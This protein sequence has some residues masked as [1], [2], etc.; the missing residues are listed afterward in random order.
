MIGGAQL[1]LLLVF[2]AGPALAQSTGLDALDRR[3]QILGWE[4][5]GKVERS[6]GFCTGALIATDLVLTAAHCLYQADGQPVDPAGLRFRAGY[7]EGTSVDEV[8]VARAVPLDG[9]VPGGA[10]TEDK[11]RHDVALLVLARSIPA[12]V[13][14]PFAVASPGD[15]ATVSV[16]SYA[17]GREDV[18]SWQRRCSVLG[19]AR[20]L[21]AFDCDVT[22][23]ASGAPVFEL[24]A[25]RARIVSIVSSGTGG[26]DAM[27][28]G[29]D[30]PDAVA[31]LK[32]QLRSGRGVMGG[33][34]PPAATV[35]RIGQGD[36]N[37]SGSGAR[38]VKPPVPGG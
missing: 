7:V 26:A 20:G 23:G 31:A 16:V 32:A 3:E 14:A 28:F 38:F 15:G 12:A 9:Y 37:R 30:L 17:L 10:I 5:V 11:L 4:A 33:T 13:A 25:G 8:A 1:A 34:D 29:M 18:P 27:A 36:G 21:V 6:D 22:F 35:R 2:C 19:R 24:G